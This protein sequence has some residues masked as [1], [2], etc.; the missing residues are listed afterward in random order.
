M[1]N[2]QHCATQKQLKVWNSEP[3]VRCRTETIC[4]HF[5]KPNSGAKSMHIDAVSTEEVKHCSY[6]VEEENIKSVVSKVFSTLYWLAIEEI[7]VG[8][9]GEPWPG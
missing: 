4:G 7:V 9:V 6:F 8:T 3:N 5:K 1:Q 2:K